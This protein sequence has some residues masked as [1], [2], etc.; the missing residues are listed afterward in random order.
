MA[1]QS[2]F[3][4]VDRNLK[5]WR[6]F[7]DRITFQV[8]MLLIMDANIEEH[9]FYN[10]TIHRGQV[11]TSVA[12][13]GNSCNLT[14]QQ[15]RTA[16]K[17]LKSTGEITIESTNRYQVITIVNYCLY[18]DKTTNRLTNK[19]QTD[20][21]QITNKQQRLKNIKNDKNEKNKKGRSAP[22]S[23]SGI[24]QRGTDAFRVKSHLLLSEDEGTVDDIP[25]MYRDM[26]DNFADYWRYRN[27]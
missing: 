2:T 18:Q 17:H 25:M 9:D 6:W 10:R 16:L 27:Q 15:V 12:S 7:K 14:T 19:Q 22:D 23:P 26:F 8:F 13:I 20:N 21:K 11:V 1:E 5:R 4:K 3:V 24:P